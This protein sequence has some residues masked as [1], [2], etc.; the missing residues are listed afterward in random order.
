MGVMS[1]LVVMVWI[2]YLHGLIGGAKAGKLDEPKVAQVTPQQIASPKKAPIDQR[3]PVAPKPPHVVVY[4]GDT[5]AKGATFIV[6]VSKE[7]AFQ[8]PTLILENSGGSDARSPAIRLFLSPQITCGGVWVT[9]RSTEKGFASQCFLGGP[10]IP[11]IGAG[12]E[13]W[14]GPQFF[15]TFVGAIPSD[16]VKARIRVFYGS[17][18]PTTEDFKIVPQ[19]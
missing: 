1:L 13:K 9:T 10:G 18:A 16:P 11:P 14:I 7:G 6:S 3:R 19:Q 4:F 15:G 2:P 12:G 8:L 17:E 5:E